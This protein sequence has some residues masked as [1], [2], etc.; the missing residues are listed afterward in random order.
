M[1]RF[2]GPEFHISKLKIYHEKTQME[3]KVQKNAQFFVGGQ[4]RNSMFSWQPSAWPV[5]KWNQVAKFLKNFEV[6]FVLYTQENDIFKKEIYAF[7]N[8]FIRYGIY[9]L[10]SA[11]A[12]QFE[13]CV[14][15]CHCW[16]Y[17][18]EWIHKPVS[19]MGIALKDSF[20]AFWIIFFE[21]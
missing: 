21:K 19:V 8:I 7:V 15:F 16:F 3:G 4:R 6:Y 13:I 9:I 5:L 10:R 2:S 11:W 20:M 17:L 12:L 1:G 18:H 14:E